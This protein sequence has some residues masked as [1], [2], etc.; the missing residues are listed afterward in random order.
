MPHRFH[1]D[2]KPSL[3][4]IGFICVKSV[5]HLWL[6]NPWEPSR[7]HGKMGSDQHGTPKATHGGARG[8][9]SSGAI[10]GRHDFVRSGPRIRFG[11][12]LAG[13]GADPRPHHAPRN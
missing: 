3:P 6:M 4:L 13:F 1:T 2:K 10:A 7:R 11:L 9:P 12:A 8:R 5:W